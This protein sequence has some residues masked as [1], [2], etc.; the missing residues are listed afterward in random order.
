M[1]HAE[2]LLPQPADSSKFQSR[3]EMSF[4]PRLCRPPSIRIC[5]RAMRCHWSRIIRAIPLIMFVTLPACV[6]STKSRPGGINRNRDSAEN[7]VQYAK[8]P[9][10][11]PQQ[12]MSQQQVLDLMGG[13]D[14]IT[15][16][17]GG[18]TWYYRQP[19][20]DHGMVAFEKGRVV[21]WVEPSSYSR[22]HRS[23]VDVPKIP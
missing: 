11:T 15:T 6:V 13:P 7:V 17:R 18:E 5:D 10:S 3:G 23:K 12:G 9:W 4:P 21:S 22:K 14:S 2:F 20:G 8:K 1:D 19:E 16:P